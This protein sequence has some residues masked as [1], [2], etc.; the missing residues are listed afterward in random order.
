MS[1]HDP[2]TCALELPQ[3]RIDDLREQLVRDPVR[4]PRELPWWVPGLLGQV[5]AI[6]LRPV[7]LPH[8]VRPEEERGQYYAPHPACQTDEE[9]L[10]LE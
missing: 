4:T 10:A 3:G 1:H 2:E 7:D 5:H 6:V 8:P 9:S